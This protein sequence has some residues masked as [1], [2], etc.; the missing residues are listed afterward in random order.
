MLLAR[1]RVPVR[2]ITLAAARIVS[3]AAQSLPRAYAR[4]DTLLARIPPGDARVSTLRTL[5]GFLSRI[6]PSNARALPE[7][8]ASFVT[9][10]VAGPEAK[11]AQI[12]RALTPSQEAAATPSPAALAR[13]VERNAAIDHDVKAA[14]LSLVQAPPQGAPPQLAQA[15]SEALAATTAVQLNVLSAQQNDPNAITIP[16][17]TVFYEGGRPTQLR[18]SRD[19]QGGAGAMD[20][21]NFHIAFILDTQSLGTI[22]IDLQTV[23]RAVSVNVKTERQSVAERF[24]STFADLRGR[25]EQLR[26]HIAA[27]DA[28]VAPKHPNDVQTPAPATASKPSSNVDMRA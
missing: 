1:M 20:A 18:I 24:R 19:K 21:D 11:L 26:Y 3:E 7:Q 23:G 14:L 8:I 9:N 5:L 2:A 17:P 4:L 22:A 16:L 25:L 28:G 13:A 12:V 6:D 10:V 15:L 27:I